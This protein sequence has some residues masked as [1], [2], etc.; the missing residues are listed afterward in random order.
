MA[1]PEFYK[2]GE[3]VKN[4][5]STYKSLEKQLADAYFNWNELTKQLERETT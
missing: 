1:D 2:N 3:H 5:T 4:V